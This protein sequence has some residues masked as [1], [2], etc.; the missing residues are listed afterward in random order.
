MPPPSPAVAG[1]DLATLNILANGKPLAGSYQVLQVRIEQELNR[2][3]FARIELVDGDAAAADFPI[4]AST[5][6]APG[7]TLEVQLGYHGTNGTVFSGIVTRQAVR[8][9]SGSAVLQVEAQDKAVKM[10]VGRRSAVYSNTTDSAVLGQLIRASGLTAQVASTAPSLKE[11]TQYYSTD[12]DFLVTRAEA[13]GLVVAV[14]NG[15]V[16]VFQPDLSA[17]P[18]LSLTYGTDVLD[19]RLEEDAT[20]QLKS[21]RCLAWDSK[22]QAVVDAQAR[23]SDANHLGSPGSTALAAITSPSEV[24]YQSSAA[25]AKDSLTAW[26][27]GAVLR[28]ELA[29]I[30]GE[31]RFRGSALVSPGKAVSLNGFGERFNGNAFVSAV[32]H[33]VDQGIWTTEVEIGLDETHF[34]EQVQVNAPVAAGL[35]P[36][37]PGLQNGTVTRI[38]QDPEGGFRVQ[39]KLPLVGAQGT[40]LWARMASPY[41]TNKAGMFFF[42]EV[43]DE[44]ILGFVNDDPSNPIILGSLYSSSKKVA[45]YTPDAQNSTKA[46][47]TAAGLKFILDDKNKVITLVTP[48]ANT[49]VLSDQDGSIS[50][51]DQHGNLIKL[52]SAGIDI[53]SAA[54]ITLKAQSGVDVSTATGNIQQSA[55]SGKVS[56]SALNVSLSAQV[57]L[58]ATG[59]AKASLQASGETTISGALVRIN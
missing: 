9:R 40:S 34:A 6:L 52:S 51:K 28:S 21:V 33:E 54:K 20:T 59:T 55:S 39:V 25:W 4:S 16:R 44:V 24:L 5:T 57:E 36:G 42:P 35:L 1:S 19:F 43:G 37:V 41:A 45:P 38:D 58:T 3:P 8:Q 22:N 53:Q 23:L 17:S 48:K 7:A 27:Q 26:A 47:E 31:V 14:T 2:L 46:L 50:L 13:N 12:W 56:A 49:L 18:V 32:T 11:I 15:T 29:K 30:Q 10:T